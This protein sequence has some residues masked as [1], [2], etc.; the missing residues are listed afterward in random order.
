MI[1]TEEFNITQLHD[2]YMACTGQVVSLTFH[3]QDCWRIFICQKWTADDLKLVVA[4][5]KREFKEF[6]PKMLRFSR[7]IECPS[8]FEEY[9]AIARAT[10]RNQKPPPCARSQ[11]LAAIGRTEPEKPVVVKTPETI[12]KAGYQNLMKEA[13][14]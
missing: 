9:L 10:Q 1:T 12:L 2:C 13:G 14:L 5:I 6:A 11:A 4:Y 8:D 7:L 3:R